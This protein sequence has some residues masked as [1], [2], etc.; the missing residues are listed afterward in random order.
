MQVA[1]HIHALPVCGF[2]EHNP[3]DP[4]CEDKGIEIACGEIVDPNHPS[5]GMALCRHRK[6]RDPE[7]M[8]KWVIFILVAIILVIELLVIEVFLI[9][10]LIKI[11]VLILT[12][13]IIWLEVR[14]LRPPGMPPQV[15]PGKPR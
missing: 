4:S 13:I 10:I 9:E 1:D 2:G 8:V 15:P 12:L 5:F 6:G 3:H 11:V 7:V 14:Q